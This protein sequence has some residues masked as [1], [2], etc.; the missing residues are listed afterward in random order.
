[1][2]PRPW[3]VST[4]SKTQVFIHVLDW[5]DALLPVPSANLG[6][7]PRFLATGEP[8]KT[9]D[10]DAHVILHLPETTRDAVDTIIVFDK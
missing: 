1:M 2:T 10:V 6:K 3:G 7:R 9:T 8:V 5:Q 4:Q